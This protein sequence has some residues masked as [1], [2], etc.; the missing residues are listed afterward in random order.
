MTR[1]LES[2]P[3]QG[4]RVVL[5]AF[6]QDSVFVT[7]IETEDADGATLTDARTF[8][9]GELT[10]AILDWQRRKQAITC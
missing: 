6:E 3:I 7:A 5:T 2:K 10:T 1:L 4:R 8:E 9:F